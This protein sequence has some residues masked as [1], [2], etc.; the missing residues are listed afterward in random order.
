MWLLIRLLRNMEYHVRT[1]YGV[2]SFAFSN[3]NK[4]LL[5][6]MQGGAG[7]S[8]TLWE[9]TTSSIILGIMDETQGAGF[10]SPYPNQP[11]CQHT[12]EAFVDDTALWILQMRLMFMMLKKQPYATDCSTMGMAYSRYRRSAQPP[13]VFLVWHPV[14]F[15]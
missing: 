10:Y 15:Y 12:G 8:G 14:V 11:G 13:Q 5:G 4:L 6:V 9:L 2:A 7:H 3:M 1:A